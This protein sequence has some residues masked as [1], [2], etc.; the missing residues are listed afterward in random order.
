[1]KVGKTLGFLIAVIFVLAPAAR[2]A[3][4]NFGYLISDAEMTNYNSMNQQDIQNFLQRRNGTLEN[5]LTFDK[6]GNPKTAVQSFYEIAQQWQITR[7]I[8][9]GKH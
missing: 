5:Y 4:F 7:M 8:G 3:D 1:M 6:D 9:D 2:A